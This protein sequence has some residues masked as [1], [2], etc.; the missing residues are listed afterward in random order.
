MP[1][2]D[3]DAM[4]SPH[5]PEDVAPTSSDPEALS[6]APPPTESHRE[7]D[8]DPQPPLEDQAQPEVD[9]GPLPEF[10]DR[11]KLP[12]EGL[13]YIGKIERPFSFLGHKILIR[14]LETDEL[15]EQGL[16]VREY[17][18]SI[19]ELKAYQCALV[20]ACLVSIDGQPM[21]MP[22]SSGDRDTDLRSRFDWAKKLYPAV[23]DKI[24]SE[25]LIVEA[26]VNAI[27]EQLGN[28]SGQAETSIPT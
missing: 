7:D 25:Y 2:D 28:A 3:E 18:D 20:A 14:S 15:I 5:M 8:I 1:V 11:F 21:P 6:E 9:L 17:A 26:Q 27:I 19:G 12:F 16:I 10:D 22:L 24:Y 13:L 4:A 23:I